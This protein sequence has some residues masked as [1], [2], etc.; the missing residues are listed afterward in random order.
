MSKTTDKTKSSAKATAQKP[1]PL[2]Q[3]QTRAKPAESRNDPSDLEAPKNLG[4]GCIAFELKEVR[5][6]VG[7]ALDVLSTAKQLDAEDAAVN[8][9]LI[10]FRKDNVISIRYVHAGAYACVNVIGKVFK[11]AAFVVDAGLFRAIR[12]NSPFVYLSVNKQSN[13][14]EFR[15]GT[16]KGSVQLLASAK[17]Y[18]LAC[19]EPLHED[20][21]T[22]VLPR[23]LVVDTF[24]RLLFPS[25]DP[26][27][28]AMGLPLNM[29]STKTGL[30][31]TSN[32]NIVGAVY[33]LPNHKGDRFKAVVP[34]QSFI[35]IVK[36]MPFETVKCSFSEKTFRVRCI[37][38]D[39]IH[40]VIVYDLVDL[41]TWLA[42]DEAGKPD[43][44]LLLNTNEFVDALDSAMCMS[45]LDKTETKLTVEF[46]GDGKGKILFLGSNTQSKS[47]FAIAKTLK[48][49]KEQTIITNGKR[50]LSFV[51]LLK[52][53]KTF[54]LRVSKGRAYLFSPD[55]TFTFLVPLS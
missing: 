16:T 42:E 49:G 48:S 43:F 32:D 23:A 34:G 3:K 52:G 1:I 41:L 40:P 5:A 14:V 31:V 21:K 39:V 8:S 22:V 51:S 7:V 26:G 4:D 19:P 9:V 50:I 45:T 6:R 55:Q 2:G 27:I 36:N 17:E 10:D 12:G 47:T 44:E 20:A 11:P 37:G 24:S 46:G 53:F 38:L 15:C 35:R 54:R 28:P 25:F 29:T 18:L 13:A 33:R 30:I